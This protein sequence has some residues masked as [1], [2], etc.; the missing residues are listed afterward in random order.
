MAKTAVALKSEAEIQKLVIAGK[1]FKALI[2]AVTKFPSVG[3][4]AGSEQINIYTSKGHLIATSFGVVLA[5]A[6][7]PA[8][9]ELPLLSVDERLLIPFAQVP[10]ETSKVHIELDEKEIR[11]KCRNREITAPR[12]QG[13][14]HKFP[15]TNGNGASIEVTEAI[16]KRG[17]YLGQVAFN[18][19]S[20]SDLC[21]VLMVPTGEAMACN[22]KAI[23]V[24]KYGKKGVQKI[25][26]PIPLAKSL[27]KGDQVWFSEKE[28]VLKSGIAAYCMPTPTKAQKE[29]PVDGIQQFAKTDTEPVVRCKG[30]LL[31]AAVAECDAILGSI[32]R[33]EIVLTIKPVGDKLELSSLNG[34]ARFK[35]LMPTIEVMK[36]NVELRIPL[37]EMKQTVPFIASEDRV[38]LSVGK[39]NG[40]TFITFTEGWCLFPSWKGK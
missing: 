28:T 29:F 22:Q 10:N 23:A 31:A 9:G 24:L 11:F 5:R 35:H 4:I 8:E 19:A 2:Q 25:A 39:K 21:A 17:A 12:N 30:D 15:H 7:A 20:R 32:A 1:D 6:K 37:E 34:G 3:G 18:D 13:I 26:L 40:E 14:D 38:T 16:A 36:E 33:T 27:S